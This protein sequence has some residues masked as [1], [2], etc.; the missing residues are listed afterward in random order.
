MPDP[1]DNWRRLVSDLC[2]I[3]RV[4]HG[5]VGL[6]RRPNLG[7]KSHLHPVMPRPLKIDELGL[8]HQ[9]ERSGLRN[10][11]R[12]VQFS[13]RG[14]D[15]TSAASGYSAQATYEPCAPQSV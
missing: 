7:G 15:A 11:K 4:P 2:G 8:V 3:T 9:V 5:R 10:V 13:D 14:G 12:A 6:Y 1:D